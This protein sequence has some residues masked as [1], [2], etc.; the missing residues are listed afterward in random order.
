[1]SASNNGSWNEFD[2]DRPK[3]TSETKLVATYDYYRADGSYS[4]T[5]QK[6]NPKTFRVGRRNSLSFSDR[7]ATG[8]KAEYDFGMGSEKP[9][10]FRL[11][12]LIAAPPGLRIITEGEKDALTAV[13]L[14]F[15]S[16]TNPFGAGKWRDEHSE[17][18]TGCA[19]VII[20]HNDE[21]GRA[22]A[23]KVAASVSRW[24]TRTRI[25]SLAPHK[26]LTEWKEAETGGDLARLI[27]A[28]ATDVRPP[29]V[30]APLHSDEG[31][32]LEFAE[33]YANRLRYVPAWGKWLEWD[34]QRWV[35]DETLKAN[36]LARELCLRAANRANKG[37]KAIASAK[38]R[39][40]VINL[41][42]E[43]RRLAASVGVWD[44]DLWAINTPVG[45]VDLKTGLIRDHR[46]EDHFTKITAVA[47]DGSCPTPLWDGFLKKVTNG[48]EA[49]QQY[50]ARVAGYS[51]TGSTREHALF[52]LYG[53]GRKSGIVGDYHKVAP[54]DT[55][56]DS[57]SNSHPTELA[58]LVGA[59]MVTA[60]ET[61]AHR[62]WAEAKVKIMTGGDEI[63]ARF[64]RQDFFEFTPQFKL[65]VAG[66][67][68]PGLRNVDEAIRARFNMLPFT[69]LIPKEEQDK[70][71]TEKLKAEWPGILAWMIEGCLAWQK[72]GL[73]APAEVTEATT[74]Y[75]DSEDT[76][77]SW[78]ADCCDR[79]PEL[80]DIIGNL[81]SNWN[82]WAYNNGE[83][84]L[85]SKAF[86]RRMEGL[87]FKKGK[88]NKGWIIKGLKLKGSATPG[89]EPESSVKANAEAF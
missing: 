18:F 53:S 64:M 9:V 86:A 77:L 55:F 54:I 62:H 74:D 82:T 47:P 38:T 21:K 73:A 78:A 16:T 34:G 25:L 2:P 30:N 36:W 40:N 79:G 33:L 49:F 80:H 11:P 14:G 72:G 46:P 66:N 27:E 75:L 32:A 43:D 69:V 28:R 50:L 3:W 71:L 68:K 57:K 67:H 7:Q 15:V 63:S 19:V 23:A 37:G 70:E 13:E 87:G 61:D 24:A 52:F 60:T 42:R 59:R 44:S 58:M 88:I 85:S 17:F 83:E 4:F 81:R 35:M 65:I 56:I 26:D 20:E 39:S 8:Q 89:G 10:P 51:L 22:H 1:M 5:V 6:G 84:M 31:L 76:I 48:N 41:A 12:E 29:I 45:V